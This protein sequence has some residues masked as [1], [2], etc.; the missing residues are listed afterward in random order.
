MIVTGQ[1]CVNC[2][3]VCYEIIGGQIMTRCSTCGCVYEEPVKSF[4]DHLLE[5]YSSLAAGQC[6]VYGAL[7]G[8]EHGHQYC[9][10]EQRHSG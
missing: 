8:D 5:H 10:L 1:T 6:V 7:L 3:G 2:A 9:D 4:E